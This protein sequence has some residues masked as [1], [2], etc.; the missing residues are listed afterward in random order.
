MNAK[1][2]VLLLKSKYFF[3]RK[4]FTPEPFLVNIKCEILGVM[5][6]LNDG[7]YLNRQSRGIKQILDNNKY[8]V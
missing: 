1:C 3:S 5:S 2:F 8:W 4:C 7:F 6:L